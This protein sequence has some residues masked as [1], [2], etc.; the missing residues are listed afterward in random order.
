[1][2]EA[3][4]PG[5][6][7]IAGEYAVLDGAPAIAAAV[8]VRARASVSNAGNRERSKLV[9]AVISTIG[10]KVA[11]G[12]VEDLCISVNTDDFFVD[13]AGEGRVKLGLGSSAAAIVASAGALVRAVELPADAATMLELCCAAHRKF[14]AGHGS[15]IDVATSLTGGVVGIRPADTAPSVESLDWPAGLEMLAVWSGHSASTPELLGRLE[16]YRE[17]DAGGFRAHMKNLKSLAEACRAAWA[18]KP[19]SAIM[20]TLAA[21]DE[22]LR[23]MDSDGRIGVGTDAHDSLRGISTDCGAVY[24]TSGAGGGDF[25]IAFSDSRQ[26]IDDLKSGFLDAGYTVLDRATGVNGLAVSD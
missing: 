19:A 11:D 22:A 6:L 23:A 5:K 21:Y 14:Q 26:T 24:K 18:D 17:R 3:T 8:D 9:E 1:M 20:A 12:S 15:G 2:P 13:R 25:G 10:E 16:N 4:A 7:V